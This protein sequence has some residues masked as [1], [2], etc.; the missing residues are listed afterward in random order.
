MG[1]TYGG[2]C[3]CGA[4]TFE[5]DAFMDKTAFCHCSMCRKFH[6]AAHG[7]YA[8]VASNK[9]RWLSGETARKQYRAPNKTTR[10][11]C[12]NCGSSL[13]FASDR[14]SKEV[15]EIAIGLFD[16]DIPTKPNA[17]IFVDYCANWVDF[18][19]DLPRYREGRNGAQVD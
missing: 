18:N 9:F 11:F 8:C 15:I 3:L 2:S 5:V 16:G 6:G 19:D 4:V 14:A 1:Q 12:G 10:T 7:A 17:H 13:N